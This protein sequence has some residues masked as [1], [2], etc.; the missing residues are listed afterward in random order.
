[1]KDNVKDIL[2]TL[3]H[4]CYAEMSCHPL[5]FLLRVIVVP[6][7]IFYFVVPDINAIDITLHGVARLQQ[8]YCGMILFTALIAY[9]VV[10]YL[11]VKGMIYAACNNMN[12][13]G[14]AFIGL[15][16]TVDVVMIGALI[17]LMVQLRTIGV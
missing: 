2:S 7:F 1:M 14:K 6:V 12:K 9:F 11:D 13:L 16:L 5:M 15:M 4:S 17:T 8:N 10:G 3:S